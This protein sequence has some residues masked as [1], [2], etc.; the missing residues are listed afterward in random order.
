ML[1]EVELMFCVSE[2]AI[3]AESS[4]MGLFCSSF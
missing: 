2:K 3:V 4:P 1:H